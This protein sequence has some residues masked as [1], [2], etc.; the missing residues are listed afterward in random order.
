MALWVKNPSHPRPPAVF[1]SHLISRSPV[2]LP[3]LRLRLFLVSPLHALIVNS[4]A[5]I[6]LSLSELLPN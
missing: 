2:D 5:M 4:T 3:F 1:S 6:T